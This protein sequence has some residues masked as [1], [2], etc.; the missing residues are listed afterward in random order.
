MS[1]EGLTNIGIDVLLLVVFVDFGIQEV[2]DSEIL[3]GDNDWQSKF[4][5][6]PERLIVRMRFE[7]LDVGGRAGQS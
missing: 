3:V 7:C 2:N 5:N 4:L 6:L 1:F